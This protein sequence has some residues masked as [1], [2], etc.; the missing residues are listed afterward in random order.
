MA[1][2]AKRKVGRPSNLEKAEMVALAKSHAPRAITTLASVMIKS[3][4]PSARI[5]AAD[6]ILDRAYGKPALPIGQDPDMPNLFGEMLEK[7]R[8]TPL[9]GK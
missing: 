2:V 5:A 3:K 6:K 1:A 7:S 9:I 4:N 8:Q